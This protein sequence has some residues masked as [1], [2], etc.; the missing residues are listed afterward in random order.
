MF[1]SVGSSTKYRWNERGSPGLTRDTTKSVPDCLS[2][3]AIEAEG[4]RDCSSE[5]RHGTHLN[6]VCTQKRADFYAGFR[7]GA[8][9][10]GT[11]RSWAWWWWRRIQPV[12]REG[13]EGYK[14]YTRNSD[15]GAC[16]AAAAS[17]S[18][19]PI[20]TR[21]SMCEIDRGSASPNARMRILVI[22]WRAQRYWQSRFC[23]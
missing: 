8:A 17:T 18:G 12:R 7:S 3:R 11:C 6:V 5:A 23:F 16:S 2:I 22:L 14:D 9:H 21:F 1:H 10:V 4:G 19:N 20:S 15:S 13:Y